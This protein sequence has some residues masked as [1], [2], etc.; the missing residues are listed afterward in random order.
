MP[1]RAFFIPLFFFCLCFYDIIKFIMKFKYSVFSL[2]MIMFAMPA[3]AG[4][5]YNG[6]Y[7]NDGYYVDDGS[8]FVMGLRGGVSFARAKMQNDVG[9][10]YG[11]YYINENNDEV[12]SQLAW[13]AAGEPDDYIYAG[14]GDLSTL[15]VKKD[16]SKTAFAGGAS[17]GFTVPHNP[18]WRLEANYDFISETNYNQIPLFEGDLNVSGGNVSSVHVTSSG[19]TATISTDVISA[20]V[21]Y[22]F[23]EGLR[24]PINEVVPYVG[25][26]L[27]YASSKTT[28]K[29]SD[30]Y[31]D[32]STDSDLQNYGTAENGVIQ[33]EPPS[34]KSKYP[35]STNI[36]L[37]GTL[38]MSYGISEYTFLDLSA[39]VMYIPTI[40]WELVNS[41][42]SQHREWFSAHNMIYTNLMV[43]LRFEF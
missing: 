2:V 4:W 26:G 16:F 22:D 7:V 3:L 27:G 33:F 5:Q 8:R 42:G 39:R 40:K 36:A 30:I 21:Y 17:I 24:K 25:F 43:G 35:T 37:I 1:V 20:M 28:L 38:G 9:S 14:S 13:Q 32:L 11:Y 18:Q 34:D 19:A 6:Y 29:L 10:L 41:D 23:F 12:V 31:G 15:P